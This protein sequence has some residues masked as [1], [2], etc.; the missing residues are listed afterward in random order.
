MGTL[1]LEVRWATA[2]SPLLTGR[3]WFRRPGTL[4]RGLRHPLPAPDG[5]YI[6]ALLEAK[7]CCWG[8]GGCGRGL[9]QCFLIDAVV[10]W[11]MEC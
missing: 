10:T 11:V 9:C 8:C 2:G 1:D 5:R 3:T 6:I 4:W 7:A